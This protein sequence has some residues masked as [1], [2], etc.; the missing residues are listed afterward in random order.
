MLSVSPIPMDQRVNPITKQKW[1]NWK[2]KRAWKLEM[3][4][5]FC[6][7]DGFRGTIPAASPMFKQLA[8]TG[9]P[10]RFMRLNAGPLIA[11]IETVKQNMTD[12]VWSTKLMD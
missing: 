1:L 11:A 10:K 3:V 8:R 2:L 12:L 5:R 4:I 7:S 6:V 9:G